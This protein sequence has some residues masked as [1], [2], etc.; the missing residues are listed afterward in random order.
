M[1]KRLRLGMGIAVYCVGIWAIINTLGYC[2][3][4]HFGTPFH[5]AFPSWF[6]AKIVAGITALSVGV[7]LLAGRIAGFMQ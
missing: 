7:T 6:S 3:A 2:V 1:N 5:L 4:L